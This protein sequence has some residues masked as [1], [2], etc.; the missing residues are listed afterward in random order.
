MKYI[1]FLT[2]VLVCGVNC[3]I[4]CDFD[5]QKKFE[6]EY[7][8]TQPHR[9]KS[10]LCFRK[11]YLQ[12]AEKFLKQVKAKSDTAAQYKYIIGGLLSIF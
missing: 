8:I 10:Q 2:R 7:L 5:G 1:Y 4:L 12:I 11:L 6:E 3:D 9:S